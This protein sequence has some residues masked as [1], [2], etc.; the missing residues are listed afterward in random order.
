MIHNCLATFHSQHP[1]VCLKMAAEQEFY[2]KRLET[3]DDE[4]LGLD[5]D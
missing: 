2:L 4:Y 3:S 5:A 1:T